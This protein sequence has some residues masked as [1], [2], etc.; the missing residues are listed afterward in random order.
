MVE[1]FILIGASNVT[2]GF[3]RLVHG[4]ARWVGG[5]IEIW[6]VHGHGR[7]Y[8]TWSKVMGRALPGILQS[9]FWDEWVAVEKG[10]PPRA[11]VTD[12]GNDILYGHDNEEI[13]GWVET[14]VAR[15]QHIGA[16]I[17]M[18]RLPLASLAKLSQT[19]FAIARRILFPN[20]RL[21]LDHITE[22]AHDLDRQLQ[23]LCAQRNIPLVEPEGHWYGIDPIHIRRSRLHPAWQKILSAWNGDHQ[24]HPGEPHPSDGSG[25]AFH[26]VGMGQALRT[27]RWWPAERSRRG[28]VT[29]TPQPVHTG[30]GLSVRLY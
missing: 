22:Q 2:I 17:V 9:R 15:L 30:D 16:R 10:P 24:E 13:T 28:Q 12:I 4:L 11:V 18:T 20:C 21:S 23:G 7:S 29:E 1:Q 6:G 3:P 26:S 19:R 25:P 8:G 27:W 5:P 14:C